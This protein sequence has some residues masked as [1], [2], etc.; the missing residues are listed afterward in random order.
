MEIKFSE[1]YRK[2]NLIT[3]KKYSTNELNFLIIPS[4]ALS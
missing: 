2:E 4:V 1:W 3:L